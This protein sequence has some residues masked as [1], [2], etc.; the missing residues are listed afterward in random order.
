MNPVSDTVCALLETPFSR[1]KDE[2]KKDILTTGR[3]TTALSISVKKEKT[4]N[5]IM[6]TSKTLGFLN[7]HGYAVAPI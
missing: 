5:L 7:F 4:V 3:P 2:D 1:W 6:L